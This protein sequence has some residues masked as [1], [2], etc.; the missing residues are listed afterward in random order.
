M[1]DW[2]GPLPEEDHEAYHARD[3]YSASGIATIAESPW[4]YYQAVVCKKAKATKSLSMG[5]IA[6]KAILEDMFDTLVA[7]PKT[8]ETMSA[9]AKRGVD[10]PIPVELQKEQFIAKHNNFA[11]TQAEYEKI[12]A[13]YEAMRMDPLAQTLMSRDNKIEQGYRYWDE[14]H[15][16]ACRFRADAIRF[17]TEYIDIID[18]K[19]AQ[20]AKRENFKWSVVNYGYD[21]KASHYV[22][23]IERLFPGRKVRFY[24]IAQNSQPYH[25]VG[26]YKLKEIDLVFGEHKRSAL[27]KKIKKYR[28]LNEWP[29]YTR[30]IEELELPD[31]GYNMED[32]NYEA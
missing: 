16:I 8:F 23:G 27:I 12:E 6:H 2:E 15:Q 25:T 30:E 5:T 9:Q 20:S 11:C 4:D 29:G 10:N 19:T 14:E 22:K 7:I 26:C 21:M 18:Y 1:F 28:A 31:A 13:M 3:E 32:F 24:F 17:G